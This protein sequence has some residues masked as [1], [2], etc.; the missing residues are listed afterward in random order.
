[1][2]KGMIVIIIIIMFVTCISIS[3]V[4]MYV[5]VVVI[6]SVIMCTL[7]ASIIVL[8]GNFC[9]HFS[10]YLCYIHVH[11]AA[12]MWT[13]STLLPLMIADMV[14][15]DHQ[16]WE[17]F[18]LLLRISKLCTAKVTSGKA[19]VYLSALIDQH[20]QEFVKCYPSVHLTPK[21]HYMVHF[22]SQILK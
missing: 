7:T 1:M 8:I 20:H 5:L 10:H 6:D 11:V 3:C 13:F 12:Q 17:C 2:I 14:S 15:S 9:F 19:A 4:F 22:P 21:M 18:L 16:A